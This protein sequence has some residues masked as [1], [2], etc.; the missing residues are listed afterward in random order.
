MNFIRIGKKALNLD[1]VTYAEVQIWQ[2][3][4]SVKVYFA[5]SANNAPVVFAENEGIMEVLGVRSRKA[6]W[7][8]HP[9][10]QPV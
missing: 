3:E 6:C 9:T 7:V 2:D 8:A 1:H 10:S 4:M 5:G